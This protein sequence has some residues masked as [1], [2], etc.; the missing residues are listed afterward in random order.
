[1]DVKIGNTATEIAAGAYNGLLPGKE[2][3][4]TDVDAST[5]FAIACSAGTDGEVQGRG[6]LGRQ[7]VLDDVHPELTTANDFPTYDGADTD[8]I[9]P[10][11]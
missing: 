1:M 5:R 3:V 2:A 9:V 4:F 6:S 8:N 11:V 10:G 7:P